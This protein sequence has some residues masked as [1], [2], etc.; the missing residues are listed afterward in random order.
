MTDGSRSVNCPWYELNTKTN[1]GGEGGG[2][3]G[4]WSILIF[5]VGGMAVLTAAVCE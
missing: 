4:N 2:E 5:R 1:N 3:N